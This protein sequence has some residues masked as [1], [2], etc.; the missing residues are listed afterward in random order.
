V[1]A[2][3]CPAAPGLGVER[4]VELTAEEIDAVGGIDE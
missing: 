3:Q 1:C 4:S 2:T